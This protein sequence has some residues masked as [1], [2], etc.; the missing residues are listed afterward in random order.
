MDHEESIR[1]WIKFR[2]TRQMERL[3]TR[4][5]QERKAFF[6]VIALL[7]ALDAMLLISRVRL[8]DGEM[9]AWSA[10]VVVV[11]G[12]YVWYELGLQRRNLLDREAMHRLNNMV[13]DEMG[14]SAESPLREP[15]PSRWSG[16]WCLMP[17][18]VMLLAMLCFSAALP[19][20]DTGRPVSRPVLP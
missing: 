3:N 7:V 8:D 18:A 9:L 1:D 15:K 10:G 19:W 13:C 6:G 5:D 11:A 4:S 20:F 12:V 2:Y 14:L 16:L 17:Q